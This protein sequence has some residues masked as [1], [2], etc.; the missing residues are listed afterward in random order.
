MSKAF[1]FRRLLTPVL[2]AA[3][4]LLLP[5]CESARAKTRVK[6]EKCVS[7]DQ[8]K[9]A[10]PICKVF[11]RNDCTHPVD[12]KIRFSTTLRKLVILPIIAEG[13]STEYQDAGSA[14][15]EQSARLEAGE[16]EWYVNKNEGKGIEVARCEA[17][18][19]YTYFR[20]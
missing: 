2:A 20:K 13:N 1:T 10:G 6:T 5:A 19:S 8:T 7:L 18:F 4:S 12:L 9:I 11:I 16:A 15:A 17:G 14:E 3:V